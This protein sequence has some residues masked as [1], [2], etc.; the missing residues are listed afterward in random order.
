MYCTLHFTTS[1]STCYMK[2]ALLLPAAQP[3]HDYDDL[4]VIVIWS[5]HQCYLLYEMIVDLD[6]RSS[7]R[8]TCRSSTFVGDDVPIPMP[9]VHNCL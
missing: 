4:G 7:C 8:F 3:H 6:C 2:C 1:T 5:S 9:R